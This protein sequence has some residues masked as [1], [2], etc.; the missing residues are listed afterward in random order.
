MSNAED[1]ET[2]EYWLNKIEEQP[3]YV[4]GLIEEAIHWLGFKDGLGFVL[5]MVNCIIAE[6]EGKNED[7][8]E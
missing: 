6:R 4:Q 3:Y 1:V 8:A 7:D 2:K 5:R